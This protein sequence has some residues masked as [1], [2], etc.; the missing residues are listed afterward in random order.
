MYPYFLPGDSW[1][2]DPKYVVEN[3]NTRTHSVRLLCSC[4]WDC[5]WLTSAKGCC[6]PNSFQTNVK[7][8]HLEP[9]CSLM[10]AQCGN[11]S[12]PKAVQNCQLSIMTAKVLAGIRN[13][14]F[15]T[16]TQSYT[17]LSAWRIV[18]QLSKLPKT[19][20]NIVHERGIY[21]AYQSKCQTQSTDLLY[22]SP[23]WKIDYWK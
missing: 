13:G 2:N 22:L 11:L 20:Q 8:F 4:G 16:Q 6:Y 19:F 18:T 10:Y 15:Q 21:F 17:A 5:Q 14:S 12:P 1:K 23:Q 7:D 9:H 3:N